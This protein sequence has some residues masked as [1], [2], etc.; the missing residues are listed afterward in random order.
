MNLTR[1]PLLLLLLLAGDDQPSPKVPVGKETTV[2]TGPLDKEGYIDYAAAL[3]EQLGK[4][5]TPEKNANVLIWKAIGPRPEG[6]NGMPAEFFKQLGVE[7]P[8]AKGDY[9]IGLEQYVTNTLKLAPNEFEAI[10]EQQVRASQRP[11]AEEDYPHLATWLRAN[12][13]PLALVIEASKRPDYFNPLTPSRIGN[14]PPLLIEAPLPGV[15]KCREVTRALA[16]RAMLRVHKGELDAASQD[17][18]ACHRLAQL[19]ARGAT[20]IEALVGIA[21][22]G[23]TSNADLAYLDRA[24]LTAQQL[25]DRLKS[26]QTLPPLPSIAD[27][28]DL[29][30]RFTFLDCL[31]L[32]RRGGLAAVQGL[33]GGP[34][35]KK[36]D[37]KAQRA[38]D[39]MDWR[40]AFRNGNRWYDRL[41]ATLRLK[42]RTE[43][44]KQLDKIQEDLKALQKKGIDPATLLRAGARPDKA[45]AEAIGD[46]AIS[47]LMPAADKVQ[48][49]AERAEQVQRNLHVAYALAV[50]RLENGHYPAKLDEL[51]P[52]YLRSVPGDLFSG[53]PL[54]YRPSENGYL[55]YSVG[56]NG[57][58]DNGRSYDDDPP[59]DD[60][61]V[62]MPLPEL[63]RKK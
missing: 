38:L 58:D 56:I 39:L 23:I 28:I 35:A 53:K 43:R 4:G 14:R 49:A 20:L 55:F 10:A 13:K 59:G 50:Y 41:A 61:R 5:I 18:L 22:E 37:P 16:V 46:I 48:H 19:V 15:Q 31:Q 1:T 6:G 63:K 11:W 21:I 2:V 42:D 54:I 52:K 24:K 17:L 40:P 9:L 60:L 62:R 27:K 34:T 32:L 12:E 33:A 29:G 36:P 45:V 30:E 47:L 25:R 7:E 26:L 51:A 57:K 44:D 8:P 3:N